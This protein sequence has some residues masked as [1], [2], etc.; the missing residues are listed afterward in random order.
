MIFDLV[1]LALCVL[2]SILAFIVGLLTAKDIRG[3]EEH[4]IYL[5]GLRKGLGMHKEEFYKML[6]MKEKATKYLIEHDADEMYF[7]ELRHR[8]NMESIAKLLCDFQLNEVDGD[9]E[10]CPLTNKCSMGN[11]GFLSLV[12]EED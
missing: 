12:E 1:L 8:G 11:S 2:A 10:N 9:C 7:R 5:K 3:V 6:E 4:R